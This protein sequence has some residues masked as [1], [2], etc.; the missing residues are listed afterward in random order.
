M[1]RSR[2]DRVVILT[3]AFLSGTFLLLGVVATLV[4]GPRVL[5]WRDAAHWPTAPGTITSAELAGSGGMRSRGV[6]PEFQ[7]E[8]RLDSGEIARGRGYDLL[9][10]YSSDV[11]AARE[12][13]ERYPVGST[14]QLLVD[15]ADPSRRYVTRGAP[16]NLV[17]YAVGPVFALLGLIGGIYTIA[18]A[19]GAFAPDNQ[20]WFA[21]A[22]RA[23]LAVLLREKVLKGILFGGFGIAIG[24]LLWLGARRG[25]WIL[26][27]VAGVLA[28][29]L[30]SAT[31]KRR[32]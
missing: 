4:F 15:P 5:R 25:D 12:A 19:R 10:V 3:G 13:L 26:F 14:V 32:R 2:P 9:E 22:N 21:R 16:G 18:G 8:F 17:V 7:F 30:W 24:V 20:S 1:S 23:A 28:W 29:G 31:R 11:A 27:A 6:R